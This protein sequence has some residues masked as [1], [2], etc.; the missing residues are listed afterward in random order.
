MIEA[1][2]AAFSQTLPGLNLLL[3]ISHGFGNTAVWRPKKSRGGDQAE[4]VCEECFRPFFLALVRNLRLTDCS[5]FPASFQTNGAASAP[6]SAAS[7]TASTTPTASAAAAAAAAAQQWKWASSSTNGA[8]S[9]SGSGGSA[10]GSGTG[11][12]NSA[13]AATATPPGQGQ[14]QQVQSHQI[15]TLPQVGQ[16]DLEDTSDE[17]NVLSK[18]AGPDP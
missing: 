10:V 5:N 18:R 2:D 12:P 13:A 1:I 11:G 17:T 15:S 3:C 9:G 7:S 4:Y 8:A 6:V 14:Q 16:I